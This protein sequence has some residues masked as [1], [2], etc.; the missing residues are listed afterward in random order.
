MEFGYDMLFLEMYL[1][2]LI[3]FLKLN[4]YELFLVDIMFVFMRKGELFGVS[5]CKSVCSIEIVMKSVE[6]LVNRKIC[7]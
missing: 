7:F 1:N 2:Y 6:N 5:N 3:K 4:I